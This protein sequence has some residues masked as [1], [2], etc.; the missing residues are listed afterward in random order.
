MR[1]LLLFTCMLLALGGIGCQP[2]P[3]S[4]GEFPDV[5]EHFTPN[6]IADLEK[7]I[8][9]FKVNGCQGAFTKQSLEDYTYQQFDKWE[10]SE[11]Q[12]LYQE[13][14]SGVS[15]YFWLLGWQRLAGDSLAYQFYTPDGPYKDFIAS[16][17]KE[18]EELKPYVQN[19][20]AFGDL[21]SQIHQMYFPALL[22]WDFSD[23][24]IQLVIALHELSAEDQ[25]SRKESLSENKSSD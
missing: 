10:Y 12:L 16:L 25:R 11:Q 18:K 2:S 9:F 19:L 24:R 22:D 14:T 13:L 5:K 1:A 23:P 6:Q 7:I 21:D 15:G 17:A 4:L 20:I 3:T 8:E